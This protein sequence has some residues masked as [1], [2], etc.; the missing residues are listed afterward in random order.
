MKKRLTRSDDLLSEGVPIEGEGVKSAR[1]TLEIFEFFAEHQ[2]AAN[3]IEIAE[4]LGYPASSTAALLKTLAAFGYLEYDAKSR[5]WMPTTRISLVGGWIH[6]QFFRDGDLLDLMHE[7]CRKTKSTV[8]LGLQNGIYTQYIMRFDDEPMRVAARTGSLRP[9]CRSAIGLML[10]TKKTDKEVTSL[11]RRANSRELPEN[12]LRVQDLLL[13]VKECR[14]RGY[15][16]TKGDVTPGRG[17]IAMLLPPAPGHAPMA[18]GVAG[19]VEQLRGRRDKLAADLAR[20]IAASYGDR[21]V[22]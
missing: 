12:R 11:L 4:A 13:R 15:A 10:L 18:I 20:A 9:I 2:R 1:R 17:V 19:T 16:F 3:I 22:R 14:Q 5:R 6:D 7:L 8:L 21:R